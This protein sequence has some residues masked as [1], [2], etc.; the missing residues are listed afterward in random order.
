MLT[1]QAPGVADIEE[2]RNLQLSCYTKK[3]RN[4]LKSITPQST[5]RPQRFCF[6]LDR[7]FINAVYSV[8]SVLLSGLIAKACLGD[9][10]VSGVIRNRF[11]TDYPLG[12][13]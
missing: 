7:S 5:Q 4:L 12:T 3:R 13:E 11:E 10:R 8:I 9:G 6:C 2:T 1:F